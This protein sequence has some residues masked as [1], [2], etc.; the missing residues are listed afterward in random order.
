MSNPEGPGHADPGGRDAE[1]AQDTEDTTV[2]EPDTLAAQQ[3]ADPETEALSTPDA[4][5]EAA[6]PSVT[7]GERRFTAPSGAP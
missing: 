3:Y 2:G 7:P 1:D 5:T 4:E 6:L